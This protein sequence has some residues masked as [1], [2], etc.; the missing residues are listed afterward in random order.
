M[1]RRSTS[2]VPNA[3]GSYGEEQVCVDLHRYG[4]Q[5]GFKNGGR[6]SEAIG[7]DQNAV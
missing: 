7:G 1:N 5:I 2:R 3:H 6:I 4:T